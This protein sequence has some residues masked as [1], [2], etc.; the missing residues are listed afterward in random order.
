MTVYEVQHLQSS[1]CTLKTDVTHLLMHKKLRN[2]E[3]LGAKKLSHIA[4][5]FVH[6]EERVMEVLG[7]DRNCSISK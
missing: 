4:Q 7:V 1:R 5:F 6:F 2:D 3:K